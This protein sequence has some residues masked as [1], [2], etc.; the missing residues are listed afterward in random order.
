MSRKCRV[1]ADL[2]QIAD[3]LD[4]LNERDLLTVMTTM[5]EAGD[6]LDAKETFKIILEKVKWMQKKLLSDRY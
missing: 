6:V 1:A 3:D 5:V 2:F 4:L